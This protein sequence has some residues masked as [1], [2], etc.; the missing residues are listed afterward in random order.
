M[1]PMNQKNMAFSPAAQTLG[2]G[3]EISQQLADA[4]EE[5]KRKALAMQGMQQ[6][7]A[8]GQGLTGQ[9]SMDLGIR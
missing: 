8:L 5:R 7:M 2:L 9:A 3:D 1:P 4:E 6:Q